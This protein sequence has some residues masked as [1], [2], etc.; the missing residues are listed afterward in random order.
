MRETWDLSKSDQAEL[1]ELLKAKLHGIP[2]YH[3]PVLTLFD[4][5]EQK[6]RALH[7][8]SIPPDIQLTFFLRHR[9]TIGRYGGEPIRDESVQSLDIT[10]ATFFYRLDEARQF[11]R[12]HDTMRWNTALFVALLADY[13]DDP[14]ESS[15]LRPKPN[16]QSSSSEARKGPSLEQGLMSKD[17]YIPP[18]ARRF[19]SAYLA[20]VLEHHNTPTTFTAR[21][22]FIEIWKAGIWDVFSMFGGAQKKL[23]KNIMKRLTREWEEELDYAVRCMGREEYDRK[24][25]KFVGAVISGRRDQGVS[26]AAVVQ[27]ERRPVTTEE[28]GD[29]RMRGDAY[30]SHESQL[31]IEETDRNELL[32]ALR[33]PFAARKV[34]PKTQDQPKQ[35]THISEIEAITVTDTKY[36]IAAAQKMRPVDMLPVLMRLFPA[37]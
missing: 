29:V 19:M 31:E 25:G 23:L 3:L 5:L 30:M 33:V 36:A 22:S 27:M 34:E 9:A 18:A 21:E 13:S 11:Q 24:V 2:P 7:L 12:F 35:M 37:V 10:R 32:E 26:A 15:A 16:H 28:T 1:Q 14:P 4:I 20:A 17:V 8:P 6:S